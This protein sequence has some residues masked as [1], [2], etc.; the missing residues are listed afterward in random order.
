MSEM[1]DLRYLRKP[2]LIGTKTVYLRVHQRSFSIPG[3]IVSSPQ[4]V[5]TAH[6]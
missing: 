6:L 3:H 1:S 4:V 5:G 2:R